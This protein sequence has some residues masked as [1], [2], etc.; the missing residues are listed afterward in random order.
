MEVCL[1]KWA[2]A[3]SSARALTQRVRASAA[4]YLRV[5]WATPAMIAAY[6]VPSAHDKAQG[7]TCFMLLLQ[8]RRRAVRACSSAL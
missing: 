8:R 2:S 1:R 7:R 5:P 4:D 6:A 3:G